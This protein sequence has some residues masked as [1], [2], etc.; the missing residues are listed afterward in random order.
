MIRVEVAPPDWAIGKVINGKTVREED[1]QIGYF[2]EYESGIEEAES[3][4]KSG[5][6]IS[7]DYGDWTNV[8]GE[9]LA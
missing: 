3:F 8:L 7:W 9:P 5:L 2:S 1:T 4:A 6:L